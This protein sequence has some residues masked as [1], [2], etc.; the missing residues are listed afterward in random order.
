MGRNNQ[1]ES[2]FWRAEFGDVWCVFAYIHDYS[3]FQFR[4]GATK[5]FYLCPPEYFVNVKNIMYLNL[6][7][8][9]TC[10]PQSVI[11]V[12]DIYQLE[13]DIFQSFGWC[14]FYYSAVVIFATHMCLGWAKCVAAPHL[15]IPKR[16]H[17][18]AVHIGYIMT[19]FICMIY[20]S[21]P[22]YTH[23]FAPADMKFEDRQKNYTS[24]DFQTTAMVTVSDSAVRFQE[25]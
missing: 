24:A 20:L 22:A 2:F 6:F 25:R 17:S 11:G 13:F 14:L 15:E 10:Q 12:R 23:L 19:A 4:F 16:Y 5:A 21:S 9:Y 3:L 7:W 18:K 8:D 1:Y